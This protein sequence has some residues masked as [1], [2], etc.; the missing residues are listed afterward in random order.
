M[1]KVSDRRVIVCA[2]LSCTAFI[3]LLF[4]AKN[5]WMLL[6]GELLLN[7]ALGVVHAAVRES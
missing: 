4:F 1:L 5:L 2:L 3:F 6:F 7:C